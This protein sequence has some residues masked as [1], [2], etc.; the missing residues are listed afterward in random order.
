M[1][2]HL[3]YYKKRRKC[4]SFVLTDTV[5]IHLFMKKDGG[6]STKDNSFFEIPHRLKNYSFTRDVYSTLSVLGLK[7][8]NCNPNAINTTTLNIANPSPK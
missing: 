8:Y 1:C 5:Y 6:K 3:L 7:K 2:N 4:F